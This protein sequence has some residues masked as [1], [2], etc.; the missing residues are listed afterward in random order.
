METVADFLSRYFQARTDEIERE[1]TLR[2]PFRQKYFSEHCIWESRPNAVEYSKSEKIAST[3]NVNGQ[4]I[5]ITQRAEGLP[6]L[7]YTLQQTQDG[8]IIQKI[9]PSCA[10]CDGVAG[11]GNCEI[12]NGNG[13]LYVPDA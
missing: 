8:W 12:C 10:N 9:Q 5:A 6:K 7:R 4:E 11:H 2:R 1:E 3:E 13:W